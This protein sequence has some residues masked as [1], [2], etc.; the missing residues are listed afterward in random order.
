MKRALPILAVLVAGAIALAA[1]YHFRTSRLTPARIQEIR[2]AEKRLA[3]AEGAEDS[4]AEASET[5]ATDSVSDAEDSVTS[6]AVT[7]PAADK[8]PLDV[9]AIASESMPETAPDTFTVAFDCT[10][11]LFAVECHKD[12][13][14]KGAER[15]YELVRSGYFTD[16][17]VFR[18]VPGFV[19]QFGISG[20]PQESEKWLDSTIPADPV[21]Q[22][23]VK[24][25]LTFAMAP[26]R[27]DSRSAQ[28]FINLEDNSGQ[29]D[30]RGFAPIG[31]VVYG[32]DTVEGF[33]SGY[34]ENITQLQGRIKE[35]G[36]AFLDQNFPNLDS[37]KRA[38]F[39][40]KI[41]EGK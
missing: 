17:R 26:G 31:K 9:V 20:D 14:P 39:V 4:A 8:S 28:L 6:P 19:V 3:V 35:M 37:I 30:D 10:N 25:T 34:G 29:L 11:G 1:V 2:E 32:M 15:F 16:M 41:E 24:G 7:P 21:K 12:W 5:A 38:M 13:A 27:L 23:N 22:P 36:N 40:E 33:Y 18:V